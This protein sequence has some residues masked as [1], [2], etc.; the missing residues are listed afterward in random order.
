[1]A[2]SYKDIIITPN[3]GSASDPKVEFRGG[4]TSANT[5][6]TQYVYA[7]SNGTISFE[8]SAGQLFS[9]TNDLT[10]SIFS[11]NDV[12]GIPSIEVFANGTI[13]MAAYGG[14]VTATLRSTKDSI[15]ANTA[16]NGANTCDLSTSNYFRRTLTANVAFTFTKAPASG[17]GQTFSL[18]L[19]QDGTGGRNPTFT[20][21]I[22]WAGGSAPPPTTNANARDMWTFITYDAGST[23][24]GTLTIKDAK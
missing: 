20:N 2:D 18:L 3:R 16:T 19:I 17:T 11:V 12:S 14:S 1:M 10:G 6:I 13:T 5:L 4:N 24:W 21:T 7:T 23:Y 15:E 22:Y 8:G 9:I